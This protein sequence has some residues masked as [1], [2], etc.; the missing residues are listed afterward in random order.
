MS[1]NSG[2]V[3]VTGTDTG[4]GKTWVTAAL[5]AAM[6][7]LQVVRN[8]AGEVVVWK[9]VE[10]GVTSAAAGDRQ[11]L[12]AASGCHEVSGTQGVYYQAPLAPWA[13]AKREGFTVPY[14]QLVAH[15]R[16]LQHEHAWTIIEG[17]G[18]LAVPLTE[19]RLFADFVEELQAP[20]LIV[21]SDRLGTVN[22]T[23]LTV[24]Y[25]AARKLPILGIILNQAMPD[26]EERT[27]EHRQMIEKHT[28]LPVVAILPH[29]WQDSQANQWTAD[30]WQAW[31]DRWRP[32]MMD[33]GE[34]IFKGQGK[35]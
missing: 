6:Q 22:H 18:G 32:R 24:A 3:F 12:A 25:A 27:R 16:Q 5:A 9:P 14:T 28:G 13:A 35:I 4:V 1:W 11:W 7:Q 2:M 34:V 26:N 33:V 30:Q 21:A 29:E 23:L 10:T 20:L 15:G 19:Q 31:R 17:A 8:A